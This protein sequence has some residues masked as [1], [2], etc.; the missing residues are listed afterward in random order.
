MKN[1][2]SHIITSLIV[3]SL[4]ISGAIYFLPKTKASCSME[5]VTNLSNLEIP[6]VLTNSV[7][8]VMIIPSRGNKPSNKGDK[9]NENYDRKRDYCYH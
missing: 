8:Y 3:C 5:D 4:C 1:R 7:G 6:K 2:F 9:K